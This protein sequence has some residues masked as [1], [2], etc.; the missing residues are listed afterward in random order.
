MDVCVNGSGSASFVDYTFVAHCTW[1]ASV[2][3]LASAL[4]VAWTGVLAYLIVSTTINFAGAAVQTVFKLGGVPPDVAGVTLL[5][6]SNAL[7]DILVMVLAAHKPVEGFALLLGS[8][9]FT[10]TVTVAALNLAAETRQTVDP[11]KF[12]RDVLFYVATLLYVEVVIR[13]D[14]TTSV[15]HPWGIVGLVGA[16]AAAVWLTEKHRH[17]HPHDS[18]LAK[19][20][21]P[22]A[23]Y[24]SD[25]E[26]DWDEND[27]LLPSPAGTSSPIKADV[28]DTSQETHDSPLQGL[29]DLVYPQNAPVESKPLAADDIITFTRAMT[30]SAQLGPNARRWIL[31]CKPPVLSPPCY[32]TYATYARAR[33][34]G[35]SGPAQRAF[36]AW[37]HRLWLPIALAL[38]TVRRLVIPVVARDAWH[39]PTAVVAMGLAT[40]GLGYALTHLWTPVWGGVSGCGVIAFAWASSSASEGPRG[41]YLV[42]FVVF[43]LWASTLAV[44]IFEREF[45]AA[46]EAW[47]PDVGSATHLVLTFAVVWTNSLAGLVSNVAI[48]HRGQPLMALGSCFAGPAW[49]LLVGVAYHI[50]HAWYFN[51][52]VTFGEV[53]ELTRF[54]Y[55]SLLGVLGLNWIAVATYRFAYT[56]G[57]CILLLAIYAICILAILCIALHIDPFES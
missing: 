1:L 31:F 11:I 51:A 33:D 37:Y 6:W 24:D 50:G 25:P 41:V 18:F 40:A 46:L 34:S 39:R 3:P 47:S 19:S 54:T 57:L 26:S 32:N 38:T 43:G 21:K 10:A 42:P 14:N 22:V 17:R 55:G 35:A 56:P 7:P 15:Q 9:L 53:S 13:S 36:D 12:S 52:P 8:G 16:Y 23:Y 48:A 5:S 49:A 29:V 45:P 28:A 27:V 44:Y 20:S 4:L 30:Q 2:P